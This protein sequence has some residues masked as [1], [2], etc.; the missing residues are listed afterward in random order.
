MIK[1]D[2]TTTQQQQQK[3][4]GDEKYTRR[5]C[6][7]THPATT[8]QKIRLT[9]CE[10]WSIDPSPL[11]RQQR[12]QE[13]KKWNGK[14]ECEYSIHL[15]CE[16]PCSCPCLWFGA[17]NTYTFMVWS[18]HIICQ[19]YFSAACNLQFIA[20]DFH[21]VFYFIVRSH[22][23]RQQYHISASWNAPKSEKKMRQNFLS[24]RVFKNNNNNRD[25]RVQLSG[26]CVCVCRAHASSVQRSSTK[27]NVLAAVLC[28]AKHFSVPQ[29]EGNAMSHACTAWIF[30]PML[31]AIFSYSRTP[32]VVGCIE[33][34]SLSSA[35]APAAVVVAGSRKRARVHIPYLNV[36]S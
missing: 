33:R 29:N 20:T 17:C 27:K 13:Q 32:S 15:K 22:V 31:C 16:S 24:W 9:A 30:F 26:V 8:T 10:W 25:G 3:L 19:T 2:D 28:F 14:I 35:A 34:W 21:I 23:I 6:G 11:P 36:L 1:R 5:N 12:Q 7:H 4:L 18:Q